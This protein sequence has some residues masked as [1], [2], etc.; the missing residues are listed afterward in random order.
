M[1]SEREPNR[2]T[3][4]VNSENME[5]GDSQQVAPWLSI[6]TPVKDALSELERTCE[7][8][9]GQDLAGIEWLIVDSSTDTDEVPLFIHQ[10][11]GIPVTY[12]HQEPRGIFAGNCKF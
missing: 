6:I 9:A 7:S 12:I 5:V 10:R 4:P 3:L 1:T 11:A 2:H 8:L